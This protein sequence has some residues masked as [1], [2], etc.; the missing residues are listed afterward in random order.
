[1]L[2]HVKI[3]YQDASYPKA[4]SANSGTSPLQVSVGGNQQFYMNK[5]FAAMCLSQTQS[6]SS[7]NSGAAGTS[8]AISAGLLQRAIQEAQHSPTSN[9]SALSGLA[10]ALAGGTPQANTTKASAASILEHGEQ[11]A[12][13]NEASA[14]SLT[15]PNTTTSSRTTKATTST[16]KDTARSL[17]D[18]LTSPRSARNGNHPSNANSNSVVGNGLRQGKSGVH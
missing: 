5:V 18:L 17:Q 14:D 6:Q 13:Q 11:K 10:L 15:S 1:V 3:H 2:A 16:T 7:P 12:S 4:S 9:A 8:P